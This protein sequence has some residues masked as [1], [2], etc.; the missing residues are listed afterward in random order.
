MERMSCQISLCG[1]DA[2]M[3][4]PR[5]KISI[6]TWSGKRITSL[7]HKYFC[8]LKFECT[9][10]VFFVFKKDCQLLTLYTRLSCQLRICVTYEEH[11]AFTH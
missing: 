6:W 10:F 5:Y 11:S 9:Q 8:R 1:E 4:S 3:N 7:T 2:A